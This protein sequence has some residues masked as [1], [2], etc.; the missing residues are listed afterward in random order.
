M[1][2]TDDD[3]TALSILVEPVRRQAYEQL[4][5]HGP[6]TAA[7]LAT[8][9]GVA[10]TLLAFHLDRLVEGGLVEALEPDPSAGRRGRPSRRYRAADRELSASAPTRRYALVAEVLLAAAAEGGDLVDTAQRVAHARGVALAATLPVGRRPRSVQSRLELVGR[11]LSRLGYAPRR[12]GKTLVLGNCPFDRLRDTNLTLVCALN[13]ALG[14][15]YLDGLG[16]S[17]SLRADLSPSTDRCCVVVS[18]A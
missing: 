8:A 4:L 6:S 17:G 3:L 2:V 10:R 13:A 9:L 11:L 5:A 18:P 16:L 7:D 1:D 12:N 14:A 15:G